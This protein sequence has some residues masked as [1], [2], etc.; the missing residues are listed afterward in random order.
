MK[1]VLH[2]ID[3]KDNTAIAL[4]D[5]EPGA[6]VSFSGP[7]GTQEITILDEI[8]FGHKVALKPIANGEH[9]I[10]YGESIG[11]ATRDILPGNHVHTQNLDSLRGRGDLVGADQ[12]P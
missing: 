1:Q 11:A 5:L 8:P 4:A 2:I 3:E 9:V 10:K 12:S 6:T 7:D